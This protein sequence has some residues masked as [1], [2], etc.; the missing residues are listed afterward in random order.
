[1]WEKKVL[2]VQMY[3]PAFCLGKLRKNMA[4]YSQNSWSLMQDSNQVPSELKKES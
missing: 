3:S 2:A 4:N 1:M